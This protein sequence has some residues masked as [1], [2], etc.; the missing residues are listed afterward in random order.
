MSYLVAVPHPCPL[1]R[2]RVPRLSPHILKGVHVLS[3]RWSATGYKMSV[4]DAGDQ[5]AVTNVH[6]YRY[7]VHSIN[8]QGCSSSTRARK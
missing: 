3:R 5:T 8:I 2:L 7:G 6:R 1:R 4:N